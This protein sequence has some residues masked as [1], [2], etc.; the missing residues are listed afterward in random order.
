[1]ILGGGRRSDAIECP[2]YQNQ[3]IEARA[4]ERVIYGFTLF[5]TTHLPLIIN[6]GTSDITSSN[7]LTEAELTQKV[8]NNQF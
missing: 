7:E 4:M 1:M 5:Q 3:S 8:L 2:Q 6:G